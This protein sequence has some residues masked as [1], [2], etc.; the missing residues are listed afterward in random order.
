MAIS[1]YQ[2]KNCGPSIKKD[3]TPNTLGCSKKSFHTW[4]KV[5]EAGESNYSCKKCGTTVQTKSSPNTLGC[6]EASAHTW[7]KL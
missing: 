6:P 4:Y 5:G 2:C 1:W 7:Y 3:S